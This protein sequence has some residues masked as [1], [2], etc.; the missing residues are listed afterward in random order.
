LGDERG[1]PRGRESEDHAKEPL[2]TKRGLQ[3]KRRGLELFLQVLRGRIGFG[4]W[5]SLGAKSFRSRQDSGQA[6]GPGFSKD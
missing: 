1:I 4:Y 6:T 5:K 3:T 2:T